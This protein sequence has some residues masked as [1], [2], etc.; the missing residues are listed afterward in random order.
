MA[1]SISPEHAQNGDVVLDPVDGA[2]YQLV[3]GLWRS[4]QIVAFEGPRW[5]PSGQ[6]ILVVRD[7]RPVEDGGE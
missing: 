3:E 7:G 5:Q 2:V 6:L 4:M 1:I